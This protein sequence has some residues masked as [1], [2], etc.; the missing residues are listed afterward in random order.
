MS[1][2]SDEKLAIDGGRPAITV[3]LPLMFPGGMRIGV[4]EEEAVIEVIRSK[5]LF[6]YYGPPGSVSQVSKLEEEF[7]TLLGV[8]HCCAVTSGTA[9][10]MCALAALGIGP[11]DEVIVPAYTWI[12][13]AA[14]V[15]A[16]NGVP[17]VAEIDD[18][19][20]LDPKDIEKKITQYTKAIIVVHMRGAPC[21]MDAIMEVAHKH[22][23]KVIEDVAQAN[24]G[25][26]KNKPLGTI[27]HIG[28]FSLQFHK[29]ITS[30]EGGLVITNDPHLYKRVLMYQ[31]VIGATRNNI[32]DKDI[33]PGINCRMTEIQG[34]L[35]VVQLKKLKSIVQDMQ[36]NGKALRENIE[37]LVQEHN[38]HP[39]KAN[40]QFR[41][42]NDEGGEI[43][44]CLVMF[45]ES[46]D[47]ASKI[48]KA[49]LAEGVNGASTLYHTNVPDNHVY[50]WW[51]AIMNKCSVSPNGGPWVLHHRSI[52]YTKD[53]CPHSLGLL[54]RTV[55]IDVS[56]DLSPLHIGDI[57]RAF[58][59]VLATYFSS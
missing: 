49:L 52:E 54:G 22:K 31:D 8:K 15:V 46:P 33:I 16:L 30:G 27:G 20:L 24:G 39:L 23:L 43:S 40:L 17:I 12:A 59:K 3:P 45:V 5:R 21:N 35:A 41:G 9:S 10:L 36:A 4:E 25:S 37:K 42:R 6:R 26:Y 28:C 57:T 19:L 53:M 44:N 1:G 47:M 56:P 50:C 32:S 55:H 7:A 18:T 2:S 14:A 38:T 58:K 13:T 34:A 29:T 51:L 48:V 11:G